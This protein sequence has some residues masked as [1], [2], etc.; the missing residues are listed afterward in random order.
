MLFVASGESLGLTGYAFPPATPD[1]VAFVDGWDVRFDRLLVTI[2][3]IKLWANPDKVPGDPSQTDAL[4][5]EA[6]LGWAV[7]LHRS[8]PGNI[9]GKG[10]AGEQAVV[11]TSLLNQ[12]KNGGAP[13]AT[14]GTR[15]AF[16][17][18]IVPATSAA[19]FV[20][21]DDA[22]AADYQEMVAD[23]CT[24]FYAGTATFKGNKTD[25]NCYPDDRKTF[26]D[27]V[28]FRLCFK[29]PTS[30]V[31]CQNPDNDPAMPFANEEHQRG[32]ALQAGK[33]TIAQVTI[34]TDH[35]FWDSVIHD[36]PA[37]FDQFAARVVGQAAAPPTVR[38]EDT[39]GIDYSAYT[40]AQGNTLSWRY[41]VDPPT[42]AHPKLTGAMAFDPQSV[43]HSTDPKA[44]LRDYYDFA[45]YNQSTQGHLNSDGLCFVKR[46]YDSPP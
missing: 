30:Y 8:D 23:Q 18:D 12:N 15:Y 10:G 26:P 2:D 44:G 25:P 40:D 14:D 4:V 46:N 24:V 38:L 17:F 11:I 13:F 22:A 21:L 6:D 35:P 7:D 36:S 9:T 29:T 32:I 37:H 42:D 28:K 34:H 3:K 5:A 45:T 31:N 20:N 41:C 39:Q 27:V 33:T 19:F 1:A 16:G 43:P